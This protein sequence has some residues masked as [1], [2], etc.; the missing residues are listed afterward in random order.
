MP[1]NASAGMLETFL[2]WM[3]PEPLQDL[4]DHAETSAKAAKPLGATYKATHFDKACIHTY[5]AWHDPPGERFGISIT[6][7]VLDPAAPS[8]TG[9]AAWFQNL[10]ELPA[11]QN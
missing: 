11:P 5:L 7:K 2:K 10:F 6:K 8:A 9:F 1:D 3:V 4:W